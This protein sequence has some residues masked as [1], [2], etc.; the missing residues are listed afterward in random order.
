LGARA[1]GG[2]LSACGTSR[3][4]RAGRTY[5]HVTRGAGRPDCALTAAGTRRTLI[6]RRSGHG[7]ALSACRTDL[8]LGAYQPRRTLFTGRPGDACAGSAGCSGWTNLACGA[9]RAFRSAWTDEADLRHGIGRRSKAD[10]PVGA[11][12][13]YSTE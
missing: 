3:T 11:A 2:A 6:T 8:A 10:G 7:G 1:S 9:G 12:A 4:N 13:C 5:L